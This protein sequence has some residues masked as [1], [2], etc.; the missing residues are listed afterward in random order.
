M[1]EDILRPPPSNPQSIQRLIS[2]PTGLQLTTAV[3]PF[4]DS[5][6]TWSIRDINNGPTVRY[7]YILPCAML[8]VEHCQQPG[9]PHRFAESAAAQ[10]V[11]R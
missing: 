3:N 8:F 6:L 4:T 2:T 5:E 10:F 7:D 9:F 11:Q 1:N